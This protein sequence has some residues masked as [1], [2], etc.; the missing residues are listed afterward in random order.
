MQGHVDTTVKIHSITADP[1]NSLIYHFHVAPPNQDTRQ[2]D[3]LMYIVA[4]GYVALD[5]TSL[6]VIDVDWTNRLF[7]VMLIA[8]TQTRVVM[9]QKQVG[10][11]VNLEVDQMGKYVENVVSGMASVGKGPIHDLIEKIIEEKMMKIRNL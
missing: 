3:F 2:P 1:P 5:G 11:S 8:Y 4:K 6:T 9:T 10:S 7:S